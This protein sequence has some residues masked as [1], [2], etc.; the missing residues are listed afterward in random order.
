M[1][2]GSNMLTKVLSVE[3][4]DLCQSQIGLMNHPMP[5]KGEC[6]RKQGPSRWEG[7]HEPNKSNPK[8]NRDHIRIDFRIKFRWAS[9][10]GHIYK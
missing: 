2:N 1:E 9:R 10:K 7:E 6:V 8:E 3:I 5:M 4:L